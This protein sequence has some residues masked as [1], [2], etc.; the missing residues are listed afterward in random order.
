M[1]NVYI[2]SDLP[3]RIVGHIGTFSFLASIVLSI[4]YFVRYMTGHIHVSGWTTLVLI[5]LFINGLSLFSVGII[6]KYLILNIK[7][8]KRLPKYS[9][10]E[11]NVEKK[12]D[13]D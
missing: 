7:E 5:V 2:N 1:S 9:I 3:L 12:R 4:Y 8:T 11:K 13:L 10:K 6:G